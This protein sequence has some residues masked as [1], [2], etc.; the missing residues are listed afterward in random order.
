MRDLYPHTFPVKV[1]HLENRF[2]VRRLVQADIAYLFQQREIDAAGSVFLVMLHQFVKA[3]VLLAAK[4][5]S[6][7]ILFDKLDGLAHFIFRKAGF[8]VGEVKFAHKSPRHGITMQYRT[9]FG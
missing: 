9:V 6:A 2:F 4:G 7:V 5:E 1:E 8:E 3:V